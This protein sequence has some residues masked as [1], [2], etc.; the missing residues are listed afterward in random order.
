[1]TKVG[2]QWQYISRE[3]TPEWLNKNRD[4]KE[5]QNEKYD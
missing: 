2:K 1:M 4:M 5:I 3:K